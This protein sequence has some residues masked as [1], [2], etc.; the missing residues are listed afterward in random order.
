MEIEFGSQAGNQSSSQLSVLA[1]AA[2]LIANAPDRSNQGPVV[3]GIHLAA[4]II[5]VHVDDVRHGIKIEFPDL[6]DNSGA[7]NGLALVAHQE[8]KQSEFLWAEIDVVVSAA[9]GVAHA[10]DFQVSN[11]ENRARGPTPSAEYRA[12][13]RRKFR[14]NKRFCDVIVRTGV[15]A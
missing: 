13:A 9:H 5:D 1:V 12:N 2:D 6:L 7:G 10:V 4:K 11:L 14:K 8:F 15:E 3:S